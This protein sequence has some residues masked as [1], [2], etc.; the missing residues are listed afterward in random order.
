MIKTSLCVIFVQSSADSLHKF[1]FV[2]AIPKFG[3]IRNNVS[4]LSIE[5]VNG[6][7]AFI[8]EVHVCSGRFYKRNIDFQMVDFHSYFLLI[9]HFVQS[10]HKKN[11]L[12]S[13]VLNLGY[14]RLCHHVNQR[15]GSV[16]VSKGIKTVENGK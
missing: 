11:I 15:L 16:E 5:V 2:A 8:S 13:I 4:F 3:G 10:S 14:K 1:I 9:S 7:K 6:G 12:L